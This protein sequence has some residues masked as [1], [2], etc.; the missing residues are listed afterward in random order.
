[1]EVW[2]R[3]AS[4]LPFSTLLDTFWSLTNAG[5]LPDTGTNAPNAFLQFC[6]DQR[7]EEASLLEMGFD[8]VDV[9]SAIRECGNNFEAVVDHLLTY[10]QP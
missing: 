8:P 6:S 1:M 3:V 5:L 2:A 4:F 9:A 7:E 10:R